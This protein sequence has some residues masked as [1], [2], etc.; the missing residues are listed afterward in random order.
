MKSTEGEVESAVT[1]YLFNVSR[2][3]NDLSKLA[4]YRIPFYFMTSMIKKRK[5]NK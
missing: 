1:I 5:I 2:Y 4:L 3:L